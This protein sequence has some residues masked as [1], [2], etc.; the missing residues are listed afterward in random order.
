MVQ[1]HPPP[2][3]YQSMITPEHTVDLIRHAHSAMNAGMEDPN[4][5]PFIGGRQNEVPLDDLGKSQ[6][7]DLGLFALREGIMPT[8]VFY[9]PAERTTQTHKLSAEVMGLTVV[10]LPDDRLQELHQGAW[11]NGPRTL[12]DEHRETMDRLLS[13]FAPP[14][15]ESMNDV[16]RRMEDFMEFLATILDPNRAEHVWVH[17][18]GVAIKTYVG[19][20]LGWSHEQ[21][22]KTEIGNVSRTGLVLRDGLWQPVFINKPSV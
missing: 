7:R 12:Y 1:V 21:T 6:A 18:H 17:T 15:G 13:D 20:R 19:R 16:A 11:T 8:R 14:E 3:T 9:S 10:A 5:V 2:P 4:R 22:F